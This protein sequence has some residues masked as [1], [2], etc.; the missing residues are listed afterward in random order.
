M[1]EIKLLFMDVDG[2]LT[3]GKIYIAEDGEFCKAFDIKDGYGIHDI[4]P[5]HK[6]IPVV[7][8]ARESEIVTKRCKELDVFEVYQNCRDKRQKMIEIACKYGITL[9][10][11]NIL[12][13]TAYIGDDMLDLQCMTIAQYI[14]C[15]ADAVEEVKAVADFISHKNGGKGAV[16]EFIEW[17][18]ANQ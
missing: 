2:T 18:C 5:R 10:E 16:R 15:P 14:G 3:D 6:I 11:N 12:E 8:T 13:Q 1:K 17:L 7:I 9:N 4:L